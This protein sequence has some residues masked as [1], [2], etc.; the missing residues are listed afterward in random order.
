[1]WNF[2]LSKFMIRQTKN[3]WT[4]WE[5]E[6]KEQH[7]SLFS[8]RRLCFDETPF[9]PRRDVSHEKRSSVVIRWSSYVINRPRPRP[10]IN[11]HK[12]FRDADGRDRRCA[13]PSPWYAFVCVHGHVY[14]EVGPT[15]RS[16]CTP[17]R[18]AKTE[19][20]HAIIGRVVPLRC[21]REDAEPIFTLSKTIDALAASCMRHRS[22][23]FDVARLSLEKSGKNRWS[24]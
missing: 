21:A 10:P 17:E 12:Y 16:I 18:F 20:N 4:V 3:Y 7:I 5:R 14:T 1:M 22:L 11:R 15:R 23:S 19:D 6:R 9:V 2:F 13:D 8:T 24:L